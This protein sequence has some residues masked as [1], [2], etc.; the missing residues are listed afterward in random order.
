MLADDLVRL[1]AL[2]KAGTGVPAGYTAFDVEHENRV[3]G[4]ALHQ[5]LEPAGAI[6]LVL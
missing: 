5:Q 3:I 6:E 2:E 1:V 4:D